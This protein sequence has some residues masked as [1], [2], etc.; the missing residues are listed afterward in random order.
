M[1]GLHNYG[2][3]MV[4]DAMPIGT[5]QFHLGIQL[6][7]YCTFPSKALASKSLDSSPGFNMRMR[8]YQ[9]STVAEVTPCLCLA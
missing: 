4:G 8:T 2:F 1:N 5:M 7:H 9:W 3:C 6:L